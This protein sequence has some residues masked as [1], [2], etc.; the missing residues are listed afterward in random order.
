MMRPISNGLRGIEVTNN[1][2]SS[3][4]YTDISCSMN[5]WTVGSKRTRY[6]SFNYEK[7]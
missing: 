1:H 4:D 3:V 5:Q 7:K 6:M 2:A